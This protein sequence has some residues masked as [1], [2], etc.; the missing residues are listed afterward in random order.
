MLFSFQYHMKMGKH[1]VAF[2]T[3]MLYDAFAF[4]YNSEVLQYWQTIQ[5]EFV[6]AYCIYRG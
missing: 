3:G 4:L 6:S 5:V 2:D 1:S